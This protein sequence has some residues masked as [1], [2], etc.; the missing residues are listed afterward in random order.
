MTPVLR[1]EGVGY[2]YARGKPVLHDVSLA[3]TPGS[4]AA[5]LGANG[6]GKTTL[7]RILA[8]TLRPA[9]GRVELLGRDLASL[10]RRAIARR[11]AVLPQGELPATAF[12]VRE[13]VAM[14]RYPWQ[15][16]WRAGSREDEKA[17]EGAMNALRLEAL[18]GRRVAELSGGERRRVQLAMAL[19]QH[20]AVL[21]LDEP[22]TYLDIR[23][24][25]GILDCIAAENSRSGRATV[26]ILHDLNLAAAYADRLYLLAGGRL[27]AEGSPAAVL[28]PANIEAAYGVQAVVTPVANG[29][30]HVIV[31]ARQALPIPRGPRLHVIGGGGSA[32]NL[33]ADLAGRGYRISLGAVNQG[34][35]DAAIAAE[36]GLE[37]VL[38]PPA[39]PVDDGAA[40]RCRRL[41]AEAAAV[42]VANVPIG[43]GNLAHLELAL[44]ARRAGQPVLLVAEDHIRARDFTGGAAEKI[45]REIVD[46]GGIVVAHE[47]MVAESLRE[48]GLGNS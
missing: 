30:P 14:G 5:I 2:A 38:L 7:L 19:V 46:R 37:A 22:T 23:H 27:L 41:I 29:R 24:Q 3:A 48:I 34:D 9:T 20:P 45:V 40:E 35:L 4:F 16:R 31:R 28:T 6:S 47:Q 36:L 33:L 1:A 21:L 32:G 26:A 12:T 39:S 25:I 11:L 15:G 44:E 10:S 18:A 42:V 8:G 17:I 43:P 13:L